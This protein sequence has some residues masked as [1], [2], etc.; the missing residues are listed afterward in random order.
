MLGCQSPPD[1]APPQ[2]RHPPDLAHYPPPPQEQ[3]PPWTR[4]PLDQAPPCQEADASIRSMSSRYASYWNAFLFYECGGGG[5]TKRWRGHSNSGCCNQIH[6]N[7]CTQRQWGYKNI[8]PA[9]A[10][11]PFFL[12]NKWHSVF[13]SSFFFKMK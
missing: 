5:D 11:T 13:Q 3:T 10:C 2:T 12:P 4:H 8:F 6:V 1:Q 9:P 7:F